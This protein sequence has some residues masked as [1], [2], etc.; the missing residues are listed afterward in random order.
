[1]QIFKK[2]EKG[3]EELEIKKQDCLDNYDREIA[4]LKDELRELYPSIIHYNKDT[5]LIS[6]LGLEV[7][8]LMKDLKNDIDEGNNITGDL[9]CLIN[10]L[11]LWR[12]ELD[13]KHINVLKEEKIEELRNEID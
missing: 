8:E 3:I 6:D 4:K 2:D 9:D 13:E 11:K 12:Y 10:T 5:G 7:I 1:M